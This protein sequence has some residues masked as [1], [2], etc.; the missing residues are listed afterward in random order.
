MKMSLIRP[1]LGALFLWA[2]PNL[3]DAQIRISD[4]NSME[5]RSLSMTHL[6]VYGQVL[7][8]DNLYSLITGN[9][10]NRPVVQA[11]PARFHALSQEHRSAK[12]TYLRLWTGNGSP[13]AKVI[14]PILNQALV[15]LPLS[16]AVANS[17]H[18]VSFYE[19][20]EG[21]ESI[22]NVKGAGETTLVLSSYHRV[23]WRLNVA[24]T[25]KIKKVILLGYEASDISGV[26]RSLIQQMGFISHISNAAESYGLLDSLMKQESDRGIPCSDLIPKQVSASYTGNTKYNLIVK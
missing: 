3:S 16:Q 22:I 14:S 19:A 15:P 18:I 12:I 20:P 7:A 17:S 1:I 8:I 11:C 25:V 23:H 9:V 10:Y 4:P 24:S 6:G 21:N 2:Q 26:D 5:M 13:L